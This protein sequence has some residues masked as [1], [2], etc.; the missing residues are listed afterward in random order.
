MGR[1]EAPL[2]AS[3]GP[4]RAFASDLRE[5][6]RAAGNPPYRSLATRAYCSASALANAAS[7]KDLPSLNVTLAYVRACGGDVEAWERRWHEVNAGLTRPTAAVTVPNRAVSKTPRWRWVAGV[8]GLVVAVGGFLLL[9]ESAPPAPVDLIQLAE[10]ASWRSGQGA[11]AWGSGT[12]VQAGSANLA[13]QA[14]MESGVRVGRVLATHPQWVPQGYLEGD[15]RLPRPVDRRDRLV[16]TVGFFVDEPGFATGLRVGGEVDF[17]V[18]VLDEAGPQRVHVVR[19][20]GN[21]WR[22]PRLDVDMS[23]Y[24]GATKLRIRVDAGD[25]AAQDW[26]GWWDLRLEPRE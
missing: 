9:R 18:Y 21:D 5:L 10:K 6:R 19:D 20:V 4:V 25:T 11:V 24:E 1:R 23:A 7:G 12:R 8:T 13:L 22:T 14:P 2:D 26:A 3:D 15:F 16:G 17:S